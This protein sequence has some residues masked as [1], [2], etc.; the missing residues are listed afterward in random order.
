MGGTQQGCPPL[1]ALA[2]EVVTKAART[3]ETPQPPRMPS[4]SQIGVE[5]AS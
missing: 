4:F 1:V 5:S 2:V 3:S